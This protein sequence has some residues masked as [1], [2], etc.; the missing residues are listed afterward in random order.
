MPKLENVKGLFNMAKLT[1]SKMRE[2]SGAQYMVCAPL[3]PIGGKDY[4]EVEGGSHQKYN[5]AAMEF[6]TLSAK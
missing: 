4:M 6:N 1:M 5:E 3:Y 2:A